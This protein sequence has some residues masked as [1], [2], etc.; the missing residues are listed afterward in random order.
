MSRSVVDSVALGVFYKVILKRHIPPGSYRLVN[1]SGKAVEAS[2]NYLMIRADDDRSYLS[3]RVFRLLPNGF[4]D[5]KEVI[6][7]CYYRHSSVFTRD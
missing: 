3:V 6:A 1:A 2:A 7:P 4:G 5:T